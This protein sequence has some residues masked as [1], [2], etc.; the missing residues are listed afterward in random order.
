ME[1]KL[2]KELLKVVVKKLFILS[3]IFNTIYSLAD[4]GEA[5]VLSYFGTS[6]LTLDKITKLT[7]WICIID[8]IMLLA[9][10]IA[11]YIDN[12]NNIKTQTTIQKYYF[13]KLQS[14]TM[15]QIS[16]THTG[17]IHKL[18]TNLSFYFFE[19]TWQFESSVIPL[20]IG[21]ISILLM[22]CRQSVITGI[23]CIIVS[24]LAVMLKFK[25]IKNKQVY[26]EKANE[27]ESKY[28]ATFVDFIQNIIAVRKLNIRDF[29][30]KK[31]NENAEEYLEA[32]KVNVSKK[33]NA[34]GVFTGLINLLYIVVLIS[35]I[36]MVKNGQ[37]GLPYLL[38]YMSALGKLY[39][40][41]NNMVR[42]LDMGERFKTSKK[43]LDEYFKN[44]KEIEILKNFNNIKL[45]DVKFSY[46]KDSAQIKIPEF[47]LEKGD[48]IS[49]M[50]E[51]GQGKTTI[52]NIL[53]GLYPLNN[54]RLLI[55]NK[56]IKDVRLDLVFV[57]QEVDLFDL[58]VRDNLCLGKEI[59]DKK[60]FELLEEA[61][62][63]GWYNELPNGLD[64]IV[65]ERGIKL[66]TGQ[67]Q[68]LNLIRGILI[69]KEL[70]F[71]D[72]PTSNL[73]I[74][75]EE[76]ITNMIEKYLK[77]KTYVIVTH[78]QKLKSLCNKHYIFENHEMREETDVI[79]ILN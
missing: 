24:I 42:L 60:I 37:D 62:L 10:K 47:Y 21:G 36:I 13:N 31:I 45:E 3:I 6:P 69:D 44:I 75:S 11:S 61:G 56:E 34:N 73:D 71:F 46:T 2:M 53:A 72:E 22:V 57:S 70:Y 29:C 4:Y 12:V 49:I 5:Y 51:S 16:N 58:S 25:M 17:Y 55:D 20:I 14:M 77:D 1:M 33:T 54:G 68:R 76:K 59:P 78:R 48:K 63:K 64:T 66:S 41:L 30:N 28:N 39:W 9:G 43:Q 74:L 40:S 32:T 26:Q 8:I 52:M 65:G 7:I 23:I 38:F 19:M 50:G 35:T 79:N 27:T 18:I 15:E 67:K